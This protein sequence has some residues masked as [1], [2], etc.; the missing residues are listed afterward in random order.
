MI[1]DMFQRLDR[2]FATSGTVKLLRKTGRMWKPLFGLRSPASVP[3]DVL[4][5]QLLQGQKSHVVLFADMSDSM[6]VI[7]SDIS[8]VSNKRNVATFLETVISYVLQEYRISVRVIRLGTC[9]GRIPVPRRIQSKASVFK[10]ADRTKYKAT[11]RIAYA[12]RNQLMRLSS[13]GHVIVLSDFRDAS[14]DRGLSALVCAGPR[15][16]L[17]HLVDVHDLNWNQVHDLDSLWSPSGDGG[18]WAI[19]NQDTPFSPTEMHAYLSLFT[20]THHMDLIGLIVE[21]GC[22]EGILKSVERAIA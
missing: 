7:A 19:P 18:P 12:V 14:W 17:I 21:D 1:D 16:S 11:D 15:V 8:A 3:I 10:V 5:S 2:A 13:K 22:A 20:Q 9:C 4:F 6:N